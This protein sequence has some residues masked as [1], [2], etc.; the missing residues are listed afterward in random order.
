[1]IMLNPTSIFSDN[2]QLIDFLKWNSYYSSRYRLMYVSTPKVACTS[3]KWWF[4]SLEGCTRELRAAQGSLETDPDLAI[5]DLFWRVA[6]HVTGLPAERINETVTSDKIFRF[7]VVRNPYK[8]VFSAWQSKM[9]L[10]EPLQAG[11]YKNLDFFNRPL[12]AWDDIS[13]AFEDFLEHLATNEA[14]SYWDLHWQPQVA[15]LRP[16]LIS[17]SKIGKIEDTE[18]LVSALMDWV[19]KGIPNPFLVRRT[20]ESLIPYQL[21]FLTS[22]SIRLI[23]ELYADDFERLA[24][25]LDPPTSREIFSREQLD[26]ALQAVTALRKRHQRLSERTEEILGLNVAIQQRDADIG[27]LHEQHRSLVGEKEQL[28]RELEI[29]TEEIRSLNNSIVDLRRLKD[30]ENAELQKQ[31]RD[32]QAE[33]ADLRDLL[34]KYRATK[35]AE[36]QGLESASKSLKEQIETLSKEYMALISG[37]TEASHLKDTEISKL[38]QACAKYEMDIEAYRSKSSALGDQLNEIYDTRLWRVASRLGHPLTKRK[39]TPRRTLSQSLKIWSNRRLRRDLTKIG[40]SDHFDPEFYLNQNPD[41]AASKVD[42]AIHYLTH[43]WRE[44]R[45]PSAHFST[46]GYLAMYPDVASGGMNPLVHYLRYGQHENRAP[47]RDLPLDDAALIAKIRS[48]GLFDAKF[49]LA[50]NP[51]VAAAEIDPVVHYLNFGWREGRDPSKHF[52]SSSYL[53]SNPDVA[54]AGINPLVHYLQYGLR[55]KRS[56]A[57]FLSSGMTQASGGLSDVPLSIPNRKGPKAVFVTHDLN[58]GGAPVLLGNI[59]RWFQNHTNYDVR[60]VAMTAGPLASVM[61]RIA[62]LHIVG[63]REIADALVAD[64]QSRLIDFIGEEPAF[65]F[66]NSV[67]AGGYFKIDPYKAPTFAYIHEMPAIMKMFEKQARPLLERADH[68]FCGG[69]VVYKY[70]AEVEGFSKVKITNIPAFIDEPLN[71]RLLTAADKITARKQLGLPPEAKLVVGCGVAHWRKQPDVFVRMAAEIALTRGRDVRF[72]WVGDGEDIPDLGK[73]A[74]KLNVSHLVEFVGH[75]EDFRSFLEAADVFALPSSEDPFPLVCLEAGLAGTP[76]VVFREA[77]GMTAVI[78]PE[79]KP[80]AGLAVP[81]GDEQAFIAAVDQ[82]LNDGDMCAAMGRAARERVL[83]NYV[84]DKGCAALLGKIRAVANLSPTVSVVVPSYNCGPYLKQRLDSIAAQSFR[85]VEVLLLDDASTDN[86]REILTEFADKHVEAKVFFAEKNGGSVFKA[87]ERGIEQATGDLIWLAEADDWCESDFLHRAVAAFATSGVRLVHGRSIP[88]NTDGEIAGDWNDLY[89]DRI[90]RGRWTRSYTEPAF[91][92]V[93]STL[94]RANTIPNASA[95]VTRRSSAQRAV[96]VARQFKL[97]GDWAFYLTAVAGG[98]I[99]YCHEAVNYHRRHNTSVTAGIEGKEAYFQELQ[100][101]G[102]LIEEVYGPNEQRRA[103][104]DAH[105]AQEAKRFGWKQPL[106]YPKIPNDI[107]IRQPGIMYG[108]GDLSGGGAQMFAVRFINRW[109]EIPAPAVL[110]VAGHEPDNPA[111]ARLVSP[112]VPIVTQREIDA[113][114]GLFSFMKDWGLDLVISGHWWGD[115]AVGKMIASEKRS[116]PWLV[117]MHGCYENVLSNPKSFPTMREDFAR[118]E[119]YCSHWV[120]T[121]EKNKKVFEE[122]YIQPKGT[123]HIVNGFAPVSQFGLTRADLGIKDDAFVFTL[124]SRAIESK[125]WN[126]ALAAFKQLHDAVGAKRDLHLFLI[127]DGPLSD[128]FRSRKVAPGVHLVRHTSRLAD[129]IHISDVCLLP[130]WFAGESLP[131]VL[132][133]FLAQGKPAIVSDIGMCPWAITEGTQGQ[134]AGIVV[135]RDNAGKISPGTL[136]EAMKQFIVDP[137]LEVTLSNSAKQAFKKF[138]MDE[139]LIAYRALVEDLLED[140]E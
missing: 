8:R 25:P 76:S 71:S 29:L 47:G 99:A 1:M 56:I 4:A 84:T 24:Y 67:A 16:D 132:I 60:I 46:T 6:P 120:W 91:K 109:V 43:G 96:K 45:D 126:V 19:G 39:R 3:L 124:A 53:A 123:S 127:G 93:N 105:I 73:L 13:G 35:E 80:P 69:S 20:N 102:A 104:F 125:G 54:A 21:E 79:G 121:A 110:F 59:A 18:E 119:K 38:R 42:P 92:E 85:D 57:N 78:E 23:Q 17:Y 61:E 137:K 115:R 14:P 108:V 131:L 70:F 90:S 95:V 62:P 81:L 51:D 118:A 101:V 86:S 130:S 33:N 133:E 77:T 83:E 58:I 41:V 30:A 129:Y 55:E 11:P 138:D 50:T 89:L 5:H 139:M 37:M 40:N 134:P 31:L 88:V 2:A 140:V 22:N 48:S 113:A 68:I 10:R 44:G 98:R 26:T 75:R 52:G 135:A 107:S 100:N 12:E 94:G 15:L 82:L 114:G 74:R 36:V 9:V 111:T 63:T 117:V 116:I 66:I 49:Y 128:A 103:G 72:V 97:A 7:A 64:H 34:A 28:G 136:A 65:T 32:H 106:P 87:W 112:D 27:H 122:G